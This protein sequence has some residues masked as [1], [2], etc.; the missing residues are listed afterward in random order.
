MFSG[1]Y[2][3][4]PVHV[5]ICVQN[6][7]FY[8]SAGRAIKTHLV[9]A[10]VI[11]LQNECFLGYTR[12]SL[13]VSAWLQNTTF[14]QSAGWGIK[15]HS[16]TAPICSFFSIWLSCMDTGFTSQCEY[17]TVISIFNILNCQYTLCQ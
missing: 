14:C 6:T 1:V 17:H 5:S 11:S 9:T 2:R 3:N 4:Q 8:Q 10:I 15:S 16:V 7:S 13:S 12:I